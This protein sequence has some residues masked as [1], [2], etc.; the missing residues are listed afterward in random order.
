MALKP[1]FRARDEAQAHFLAQL[2][3]AS[4]I[5]ASVQGAGL[6]ILTG[7]IPGHLVGPQVCVREEDVEAARP[8]VETFRNR[9]GL[10]LARGSD[11]PWKCPNCGEVLEAQ[12]T[13]C[14]N[15]QTPR[16]EGEDAVAAKVNRPPPDP[17]IPANLH[18]VN[19]G[20][21]LRAL[22]VV[23]PCPE[24]GHPALASVMASSSEQLLQPCLDAAE[25]FIGF[26][27]EA[28]QYL[29]MVWPRAVGVYLGDDAA[30]L[31]AL[32]NFAVEFVGSPATAERAMRR[33]GLD[34]IDN[35]RRLVAKL[36]DL[37]MLRRA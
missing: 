12:F 8:I 11:E 7:S 33:W 1:V 10:P 32:Q 2:L 24:C 25:A 16:P 31:I 4:D 37:G 35:V 23:R 6:A 5:E 19:C 14:W 36:T 17:I 29:I 18:C 34:Q 27:M 13:D 30:L 28:V 20:Y 3:E 9:G 15:C 21:N 26:P 22:S